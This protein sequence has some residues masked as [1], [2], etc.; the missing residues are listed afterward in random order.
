MPLNKKGLNKKLLHQKMAAAKIDGIKLKVEEESLHGLL[1]FGAIVSLIVWF[2]SS[3]LTLFMNKY[4]LPTLEAEPVLFCEYIQVSNVSV[5]INSFTA[6]IY[7]A[8]LQVW[9]L[10]SP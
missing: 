10:R 8:P 5:F 2:L 9:L 3:F 7:I 1:S 4:S 6:D